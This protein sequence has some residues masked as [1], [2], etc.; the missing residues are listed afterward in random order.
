M[1]GV[2]GYAVSALD[3]LREFRELIL[4]RYLVWIGVFALLLCVNVT[5]LLYVLFRGLSMKTTGRKLEHM[6]AGLRRGDFGMQELTER[7]S[8]E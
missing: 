7:L 3:F 5:A 1:V 2:I 4:R 6:D 8:R